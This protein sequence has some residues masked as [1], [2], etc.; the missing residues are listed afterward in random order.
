MLPGGPHLARDF[1]SFSIGHSVRRGSGDR[2]GEAN[3]GSRRP[4]FAGRHSV[5]EGDGRDV[6]GPQ[7][8]RRLGRR[9]AEATLSLD[10][11]WR[12][13]GYERSRSGEQHA[14]GGVPPK[15]DSVRSAKWSQPGRRRR[16]TIKKG[17]IGLVDVLFS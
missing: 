10:P 16:L 7:Q 2:V 9:I 17:E 13:P 8:Q 3:S 4:L 6:V 14:A 15:L 12:G 5:L 11:S 1:A